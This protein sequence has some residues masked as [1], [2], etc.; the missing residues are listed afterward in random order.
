M[1]EMRLEMNI[2]ITCIVD[3]IDKKKELVYNKK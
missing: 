2:I 3:Y 1:L